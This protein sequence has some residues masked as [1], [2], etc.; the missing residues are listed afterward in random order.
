MATELR[1][2]VLDGAA[3]RSA[4]PLD[5][6][7]YGDAPVAREEHMRWKHLEGPAGP[8]VALQLF[9]GARLIGRVCLQP[10]AVRACGRS[11]RGGYLTDLVL[12]PDHRGMPRFLALL[13]G[14]RKAPEF[15]F[16]YV[17]PNATSMPL[18]ERVLGFRKPALLA[19]MAAPLRTASSLERLSGPRAR[20]LAPL[21]D[22]PL[23][24]AIEG[25]AAASPP[26]GLSIDPGWP[27]DGELLRLDQ[28]LARAAFP[29]AP[30]GPGFLGWRF[31][32]G[33]GLGYRMWSIRRRGEL[34]GYAVSRLAR[35]E[36]LETWFLVDLRFDP[37]LRPWQILWIRLELLRLA[38]REGAEI[39]LGIFLR[40]NPL[41]RRFCGLPWLR[42]PEGWLPQ[43]VKL[44]V[45]PVEGGSPIGDAW[46]CSYLTLADLD[47]F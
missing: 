42:I 37:T 3:I 25:L 9:Q 15:D 30:R 43:A 2:S 22:P 40:E 12:H 27:G 24:L 23:G 13:R 18:Y 26:G 5:R 11:L 10:R 47:V 14:I 46:R 29:S 38:R 19:V 7:V 39:A 34:V 31:S 8:S 17:T 21:L 35:Y 45:E 20:R 36:G 16:L 4:L 41:L 32:E 44:F 1:R 33:S 28:A 6:S